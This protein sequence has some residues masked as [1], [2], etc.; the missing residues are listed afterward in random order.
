MDHNS[1]TTTFIDPRLP[2]IEVETLPGRNRVMTE[3]ALMSGGHVFRRVNQTRRA[4]RQRTILSSSA[5][6]QS[7]LEMATTRTRARDHVETQRQVCAVLSG[8]QHI[9]KQ[10]IDKAVRQGVTLYGY[11]YYVISRDSTKTVNRG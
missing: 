6:T 3:S 10:M 11:L 1:R 2:L 5:D 7:W 8:T 9:V 4:Q